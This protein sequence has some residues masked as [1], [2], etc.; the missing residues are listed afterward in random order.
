[1]L[2]NLETN[3]MFHDDDQLV[4]DDNIVLVRK[5]KLNDKKLNDTKLYNGKISSLTLFDNFKIQTMEIL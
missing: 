4:D 3:Y 1:M 2:E 5:R